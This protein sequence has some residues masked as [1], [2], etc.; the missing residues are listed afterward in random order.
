MRIHFLMILLLQHIIT[1]T[2]ATGD[3]DTCK[4]LSC[5]G[6][7]QIR[8]PFRIKDKQ[9][10]HCGYPGFELSCTNNNQTEIE[11][12]FAG[13]FLVKDINYRSQNVE[14]YDQN[15]CI[16]RRLIH[17]NLS[18]DHTPFKRRDEF[19]NNYFSLFNCSWDVTREHEFNYETVRC[20]NSPSLTYEVF[21][22]INS[23]YW[24]VASSLP[25]NCVLLADSIIWPN[26]G[27]LF[28]KWDEPQCGSCVIDGGECRYKNHSS[29]YAIEC[30]RNSKGKKI[31]ISV[32]VG[33]LVF[34]LFGLIIAVKVDNKADKEEKENQLRIEQFL[35]NNALKPTRYSHAEIKKMTN[36]FETKLGQGGYGSVFEGKLTDGI[37]V[38]VKVLDNSEGSNNGEEFVNEVATI[39]RIHHL[40]VV[41]LLGFCVEGPMRALVYEFMLN[42]SLDKLIFSDRKDKTSTNLDWAKLEEI[43]IGIARGLE[44]LHQGCDQRILHFDIKPQNIL[45]DHNFTPKIS[46]FGLAKL[47]TKDTYVTISMAA[48]R[49]TMG[50]IAPEVFSRNFGTIS[51]KSDVYSFGMLLLEM[52]K[53]ETRSSDG[54]YFPEWVYNRLNRGEEL[55]G[56]QAKTEGL[57]IVK[58]LT[59]VAL[60]CIQ[61]DPVD[62]PSMNRVL[63]MLQGDTKSLFIAPNPFASTSSVSTSSSGGDRKNDMELTVILE[64]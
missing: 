64:D 19:R 62:R 9:P 49:G 59:M 23:P 16:P 48:A 17:F 58:K 37:Q 7:L 44:Y 24:S 11:L 6:G 33:I 61:W 21:A 47:C 10:I 30:Y 34:L 55:G 45:L 57:E 60:W 8:F 22:A 63:R 50:Y 2:N 56:I 32:C 31:A 40:N 54:E 51:Y 4:S 52:V 18:S 26:L 38:A 28:M 43:A 35:E 14:I 13:K 1:A 12:P 29:S 3:G 39:G 20:M 15:N 36:K 46:D 53:M 5:G 42:S 27:S 41:R 25:D